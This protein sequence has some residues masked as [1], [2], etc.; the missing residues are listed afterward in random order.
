MVISEAEIVRVIKVTQLA[1]DVL[2]TAIRFLVRV[3]ALTNNL[4]CNKS[5]KVI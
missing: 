4:R 1:D 5:L 2:D 3:L